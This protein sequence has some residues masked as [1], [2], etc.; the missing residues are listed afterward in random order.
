MHPFPARKHESRNPLGVMS[1]GLSRPRPARTRA[2]KGSARARFT[3][4]GRPTPVRTRNDGA[5][6]PQPTANAIAAVEVVRL[7]AFF[8]LLAI[9]RRW[10]GGVMWESG[11]AS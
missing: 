6:S 7:S 4:R 1:A 8:E 9:L 2:H 5:A 10:L 11:G 3:D